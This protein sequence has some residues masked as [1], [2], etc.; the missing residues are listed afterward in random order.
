MNAF[1]AGPV[2][3]N[4]LIFAELSVGLDRVEDLEEAGRR[5]I[6]TMPLPNDDQDV[7]ERDLKSRLV[8]LARAGRDVVLDF[9]LWSRAIRHEYRD[10]SPHLA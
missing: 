10:F 7:I 8:R 9:S 1:D 4:P 3:I 2:V 6:R 5:G